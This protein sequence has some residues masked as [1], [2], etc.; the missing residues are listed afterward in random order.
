M[1][2]GFAKD[3]AHCCMLNIIFSVVPPI[4]SLG[5][6]LLSDDVYTQWITKFHVTAKILN[7]YR[8]IAYMGHL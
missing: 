1:C 2:I 8:L 5:M 3:K 4:T 7:L 6:W